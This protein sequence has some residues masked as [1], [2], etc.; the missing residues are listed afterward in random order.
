MTKLPKSKKKAKLP[1]NVDCG[2][3]EFESCIHMMI[4]VDMVRIQ[5]NA[6]DVFYTKDLRVLKKMQ[7]FIEQSI[8]YLR[9]NK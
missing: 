3:G 2:D 6:D 7:K 9:E 8:E 4:F 1:N 5:V